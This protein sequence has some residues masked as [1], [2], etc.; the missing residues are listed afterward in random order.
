VSFPGA[1]AD[2]D[3]GILVDVYT[4]LKSYVFPGGPVSSLASADDSAHGKDLIAAFSLAHAGAADSSST[5]SSS[6][7]TTTAG[8]AGGVAAASTSTSSA[9]ASTPT[10]AGSGTMCKRRVHARSWLFD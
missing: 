2:D 3:A 8:S 9:P 5:G 6:A 4:N 1:Y 7:N 10:S